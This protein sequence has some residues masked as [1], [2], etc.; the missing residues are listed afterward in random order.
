MAQDVLAVTGAKVEPAQEVDQTLVEAEDLGFLAGLFAQFLDVFFQFALGGNDNFLDA[1]GMNAAVGNEFFQGHARD[2]TAN[3]V[4]GADDNHA[5]SIVDDHVHAGGFFEG[6]D[7]STFAADDAAFHFV[8]GDA[9]GA[10][11]GFGGVNGGVALQGSEQRFAG[12]FLAGFGEY[13]FVAED[14]RPGLLLELLVE[15]FQEAPGGFLLIEP[16]KLVQGLPLQVEQFS[17]FF[18]AV[19]G[20]LDAFG[21]FALGAFHYFFLFAQL[22]GLFFQGILAFVEQAFAFVQFAAQAA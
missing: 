4:E 22:L 18:L 20:F 1:G 15:D 13:F 14:D 16:A 6:A 10:G 12:F 21:E 11:C 2:F 5:G 7:V 19:V 3:H 17:E 8:V 9:H